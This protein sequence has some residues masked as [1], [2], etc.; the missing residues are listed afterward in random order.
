[1]Q[2]V[3][4]R[5]GAGSQACRR[6][7]G[8][9]QQRGRAQRFTWQG[10]QTRLQPKPALHHGGLAVLALAGRVEVAG[11]RM[12]LHVLA[13]HLLLAAFVLAR[14]RLERAESPVR[15]ELRHRAAP[16]A[17]RRVL[18]Y[19]VVDHGLEGSDPLKLLFVGLLF[20][21]RADRL[22]GRCFLQDPHVAQVTETVSLR[23]SAGGLLH[24]HQTHSAGAGL[25]I[26]LALDQPLG[27]HGVSGNEAA[28]ER[29]IGAIGALMNRVL[30]PR[31][32]VV[33]GLNVWMGT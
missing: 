25:L 31:P 30:Q 13:R 3:G 18:A 15:G 20:T 7:R 1:L 11:L 2:R 26:R 9:R 5:R 12:H 4:R 24:E 32:L 23:A 8:P 19:E 33:L 21:D 10:E 14:N 16:L 17:A 27:I 28:S 29:K 22:G 6:T